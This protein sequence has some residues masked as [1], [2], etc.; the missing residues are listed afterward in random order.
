MP[1]DLA[2][3]IGNGPLLRPQDVSPSHAALQVVG[4]FNPAAANVDGEFVLLVRIAERARAQGV[5][6]PDALTIDLNGPT[7]VLKPLDRRRRAVDVVPITVLD[8]EGDRPSITVGYLPRELR[9]LD[10][11]DPRGVSFT[12]PTTGERAA[13]ITQLS[14]L[15]V[16]RSRDGISFVVDDEPAIFPREHLE[17]YG[18]EDAR[19][20]RIDGQWHVTYVSVSRMGITT[21]LATTRTSDRSSGEV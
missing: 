21:S 16:A 8:V 15:R 5:L 13:F 18:C 6:P 11:S 10:M 17:E 1:L 19:A 3:R 2:R 9:G 4:V 14:H 12:H 7:P 20:T